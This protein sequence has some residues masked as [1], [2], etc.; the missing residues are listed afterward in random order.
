MST[1]PQDIRSALCWALEDANDASSAS[2][3]WLARDIDH[4]CASAVALLTNPKTPLQTLRRAKSAYKTMR[5]IGET[6]SDRRLGARL[7]LASIAA[8]IVYHGQRIST[9]TDDAIL[10]SLKSLEH[11]MTAPDRLRELATLTLRALNK[12]HPRNQERHIRGT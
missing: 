5:I 9:Q 12:P 7:Y 8:A 11:D 10:R 1:C 3:D 6:A 2:A 4:R